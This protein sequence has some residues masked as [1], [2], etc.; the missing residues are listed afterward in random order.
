MID[1]ARLRAQAERLRVEANALDVAADELATLL[2]ATPAPARPGP[3]AAV[4]DPIPSPPTPAGK[5]LMNPAAFFAHL[6]S[7]PLFGKSLTQKQVEGC[8]RLCRIGAGVLPLVWMA[9]VLGQVYHEGNHGMQP[10]RE[11][12]SHAYLDQYDTGPK[13]VRLGNTPEDDDDGQLYAGRGDIQITGKANYRKATAMLRKLGLISSTA[14]LVK[15]PDLALDPT[16]S[17]AIA[18]YGCRDGLFTGARLGTYI[19]N[20]GTLKQFKEARRVVNGTDKADLIAGYCMIF[21][22]ALQ[23]GNWL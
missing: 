4:P 12:G 16:I 17:G 6:R 18:V 14:D 5:G 1:P 10:I 22:A 13:A 9:A 20:A 23:A 7:S 8:E 21:K 3:P 11:I 2:A 15:T 19:N